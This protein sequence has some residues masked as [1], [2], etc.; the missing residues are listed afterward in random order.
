MI[1]VQIHD[2][3]S[4]LDKESSAYKVCTLT[5]PHTVHVDSMTPHR[6]H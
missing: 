3:L 1:G 5:L 4:L 6:L 2:L